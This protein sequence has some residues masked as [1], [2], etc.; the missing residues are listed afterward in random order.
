MEYDAVAIFANAIHEFCHTIGKHNFFLFGEVVDDE[1]VLRRYVG[2]NARLPDTDER[3]P[4][5]DA[6]L[7]FPLYFLLEE[8]IKGSSPPAPL[9]DLY[10][11]RKADATSFGD[12]ARYFV[13]FVDNHDQMARP[14]RRFAAGALS[15]QQSVNV[16]GFLL[17]TVGVPCI[18]YG[19]EQGLDGAGDSDA[20]VRETLFPSAWGAFGRSD[21]AHFDENHPIYRG[22]RRLAAVRRDEPALRY[23][24]LYFREISGNGTDFGPPVDGR[25]TLAYSRILDQTEILVAINLDGAARSDCVTVDATLSPP[26]ARILDLLSEETYTIESHHGRAFVRLP[27]GPFEMVIL[28][29]AG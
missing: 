16:L 18:Y 10:G 7:D 8:I 6:C 25:C 19:T 11:R 1:A 27:L 28:R 3:F 2:R 24:R 14:Y 4:S 21:E 12:V 13:T 23:G 5:L 29:R 17:T 20:C 9:I 15:A 26:G 22:I